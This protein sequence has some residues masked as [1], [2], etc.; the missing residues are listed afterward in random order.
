MRHMYRWGAVFV[1][2]VTA[3]SGCTAINLTRLQP[4]LSES[5][6]C[7][8]HRGLLEDTSRAAGERFAFVLPPAA[9]PTGTGSTRTIGSV[10]VNSE[11]TFTGFVQAMENTKQRLPAALQ[12]DAVTKAFFAMMVKTSAQAQINTAKALKIPGADKQESEV[13][14][15][16]VPSRLTHGELKKFADKFFDEQL[17]PTLVQPSSHA[18]ARGEN[19]FATYFFA[20]YEGKFFDRFGQSVQKPQLSLTIPDAEIAAALTVLLEYTVDI[21][22]PTP[23][24][25][26]S[27]AGG[28]GTTF[29]P[30]NNTNEPTAFAAALAR[31]GKIG[32]DGCGVTTKN[33]KILADLANA[34]GDRAATLS[35]LVSQSTGGLGVSLGVF[36][37][38]SIGDNQ[39]LGT[40]IKTVASRLATRLTFAAS[41]WALQTLSEAPSSRAPGGPDSAQNYLRFPGAP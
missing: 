17:R 26:S 29:Y 28:T 13:Q 8:T 10:S 15:Y 22:D 31:Y 35:G 21:F 11:S 23:V 9:K 27:D 3:L 38:I 36:G 6:A 33:V 19:A 1:I 39:T 37:K 20:Y 30:G 25:G 18:P 34:A 12:D 24:M 32:P 41:Y 2:A 16:A 14:K 4:T 5:S 7:S 40:I